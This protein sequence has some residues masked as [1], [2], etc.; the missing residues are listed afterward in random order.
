[1]KRWAAVL[2]CVLGGVLLLR[3]LGEASPV[4]GRPSPTKIRV[5]AHS[6]KAILKDAMFK[7]GER[8]CVIVEGDHE[9]VINLVL[10]VRDARGKVVA[11]DSGGGDICAVIWYPPRTGAYTVWLE[12]NQNEYNDVTLVVQ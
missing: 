3:S 2:G 6:R 7:G 11:R 5:G 12:N 10:E 9:P 4:D 8:A 1:M